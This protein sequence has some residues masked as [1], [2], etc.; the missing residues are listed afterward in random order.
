[1]R[2]FPGGVLGE[3]RHGPGEPD[4]ALLLVLATAD[5]SRAAWLRA[6]E[7]AGAVLLTATSLG[8]AT[9]PLSRNTEVDGVQTRL[10]ER[11]LPGAGEPQLVIRV[12]YALDTADA[13][14]TT[15]CRPANAVSHPL[16]GAGKR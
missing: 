9:C 12:G 5:D 14:P 11:L 16:P 8:L 3:P 10:R 7:A 4:A 15:P 1:M 2:H 13:L 6:G